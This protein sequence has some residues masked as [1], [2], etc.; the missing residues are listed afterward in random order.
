[1]SAELAHGPEELAAADRTAG[2]LAA[3]PQRSPRTLTELAEIVGIAALDVADDHPV[4][5]VPG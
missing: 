4:L 1:M 5:R 2:L 3:V